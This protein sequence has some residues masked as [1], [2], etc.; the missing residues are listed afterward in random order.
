MKKII[1]SAI[2]CL[3]TI[4]SF[5]QN[6]DEPDYL[7]AAKTPP[8]GWN[9]WDCFAAFVNEDEV[10][11]NA[12]YIRDHLKQYGWKYVTVDIRW[13]V[14]NETQYYNL[15]NPDYVIDKYG[16]Y[17]PATNRFPSAADGNGFKSLADKIHAMGLKFGIHIMRGLPKVAAS[18]KCPVYNG[19]GITCDQICNN[20]SA[21][22]WC[23]QNYKV[24]TGKGGQ[25]Y[26]NSIFDLY[27]Q[28]GVDFVKVDDI[29][30]PVHQGEISMIHNAIAQC[31]RPIVL[32]LSPGKADLNQADFLSSKANQW[33]M[34]DDLWDKW[35]DVYAIFDVADKWQPF[36]KVGNWP[37]ADMIPIGAIGYNIDRKSFRYSKLTNDEEQTLMNLWGICRSPM[38]YGGNLPK[39][40][41]WEDSLLTNADLIY[42]NQHGAGERQVS[43]NGKLI[44]WTSIDPANGDRFVAMFNTGA[45]TDNWFSTNGAA[46]TSQT[47]AYTTTGRAE[48]ADVSLPN[49]LNE[50]ALVC[51]DA[52]DGNS[53]DHA[54]WV[55]PRFVLSDGSEVDITAADTLYSNTAHAYDGYKF[56]RYGKNLNGEALKISGTAYAKGFSCHAS[57]MLVVKVPQYTD[58]RKVVGLRAK[59]GI[60]DSGALQS[61][62]TSSVKFYVFGFD[63]TARD[64]FD[65]SIAKAYSGLVSRRNN[66]KGMNLTA[67]ISGQK[68]LHLVVS[69]FTDNFYYD[70]ADW[71]NPVL[72]DEN[73]NETSLLS[74]DA[75][76]YTS[77]FGSLHKNTNVEGGTLN[78]GGTTYAKG[79]GM[80]GQCV[81]TYNIPTDKKYV[82][83]KAFVGL[84][85]SVVNDAPSAA[86]NATVE[87]LVF[88]D[89]MQVSPSMKAALPLTAIG[90]DADRKCEITDLWSKKDMGT[91]ANNDFSVSLNAHQSALYRITPLNR[92]QGSSLDISSRNVGDD[93]YIDVTLNGAPDSSS[94]VVIM[95]DDSILGSQSVAKTKSVYYHIKKMTGTHTFKALYSGTASEAS[96]ESKSITLTATKIASVINDKKKDSSEMYAVDGKRLTIKPVHGIYIQNGK[97]W[98]V[99]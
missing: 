55:N 70:R 43:N 90:M 8:M 78:I 46:F 37:D 79:L 91:F 82:Q 99:D 3:A 51:D 67:D 9:S 14:S 74:L 88:G 87:F 97:A 54:D 53:Y 89:D 83:F 30:R 31:G 24:I 66:I 93:V 61:G 25:L 32:S 13:Y 35:A 45:N 4:A 50:V 56:F 49:N 33:R 26:Y 62:S 19:G 48:D 21:C 58:G 59:C 81:A 85:N 80:N 39:N 84:D 57:S 71:M 76:S 47:I 42:M 27:A 40:T 29:S 28:W 12:E 52:S 18:G 75:A 96:C 10:L 72:V 41:A 65:A 44:T 5:A 68:Q 69:R 73:G 98:M 17:T 7:L 23:P 92:A 77:D 63:P 22:S 38:I 34:V 16:R 94:Y 2:L 36:C 95:C 60:D 1:L 11:A 86:S 15:T 64:G 20:D 6:G